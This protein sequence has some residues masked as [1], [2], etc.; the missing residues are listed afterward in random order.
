MS[1]WKNVPGR[2]NSKCKCLKSG[3]A[4]NSGEAGSPGP[5]GGEPGDRLADEVRGPPGAGLWG[6]AGQGWW[7]DESGATWRRGRG[8]ESPVGSI[9]ERGPGE[10]PYV[11]L[12]SDGP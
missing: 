8:R 9:T 3:G 11:G 12:E 7:G 10:A 2:K 6:L 4:W 5:E 1:V